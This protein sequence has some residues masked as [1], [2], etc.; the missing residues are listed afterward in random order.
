MA[1]WDTSRGGGVDNLGG[2]GTVSP[3]RRG[4]SMSRTVAATVVGIVAVVVVLHLVGLVLG[5][6]FL[7]LKLALL[8]ALVAGAVFLVRRIL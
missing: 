8:V 4:G 6:F 3:R 1:K 2:P 5:A 7:V